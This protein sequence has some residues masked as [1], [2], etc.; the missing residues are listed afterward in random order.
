[1]AAIVIALAAVAVLFPYDAL[2]Q[3]TFKQV[4]AV[5]RG[6]GIAL[7][8][9]ELHFAAPATVNFAGLGLQFPI[10]DMTLP[11]FAD[12]GWFRLHLTPSVLYAPTFRSV[13]ELY[14]GSAITSLESSL[15]SN[16]S[17]LSLTMR[18]LRL[19]RHPTLSIFGVRGVISGSVKIMGLAL[20]APRSALPFSSG[21][22]DL[23]LRDGFIPQGLPLHPLVLTPEAREIS[24]K[25]SGRVQR[26]RIEIEKASLSSSLGHA[27]GKGFIVTDRRGRIVG[28]DLTFLIKVTDEG[29]TAVGQYLALAAQEPLDTPVRKWHVSLEQKPGYRLRSVVAPRY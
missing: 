2:L 15:L 4:Q 22:W 20:G 18:D 10:Q 6:Q 28:M 16:E 17:T 11:F 19:E 29:H 27:T 9:R 8:V 14:E 3:R 12:A 7:D 21:S 5:A 1:M 25:F 26:D 23:S 24:L 13:I